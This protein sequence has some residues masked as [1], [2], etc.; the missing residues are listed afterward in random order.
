MP[1][2]IT[3][4]TPENA[5]I[6]Y[7]LAGVASRSGAAVIDIFIQIGTCAVLVSMYFLMQRVFYLPIIGWPTSVLIV[8]GFLIL[9]GYYVFF[10]TKWAGQTPGK[11]M[12]RLRTIMT[13]GAPVGL[14]NAAIRGL[15]RVV[16]LGFFIGIICIMLTPNNQRLGDFAAG[17]IVVKEREQWEGDL[18]YKQNST[19]QRTQEDRMVKNIELVS[20]EQFE[21][22]KRFTM[23]SAEL[24]ADTRK[25]LAAKIARPLMYSLGIDDSP[26]INYLNLLWAIYNRCVEERGML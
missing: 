17:T 16:D 15:I 10:E 3:V 26:G 9:W 19:N 11:R 2:Q 14:A 5:N 18:V 22:I 7:E 8:L 25:E 1:K 20:A 21:A 4:T 13:S 6:T 23:R 24:E 12:C